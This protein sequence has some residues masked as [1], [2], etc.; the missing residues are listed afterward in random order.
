M[1]SL[2]IDVHPSKT[3]LT[4]SCH[5]NCFLIA[6]PVSAYCL[7]QM[8]L[9]VE[10]DGRTRLSCNALDDRRSSRFEIE[11][12]AT[13]VQTNPNMR[14]RFRMSWWNWEV[15]K[16]LAGSLK[17]FICHFGQN[18]F[19]WISNIIFLGTLT[20]VIPQLPRLSRMAK[21]VSSSVE[22]VNSATSDSVNSCNFAMWAFASKCFPIELVPCS[23]GWWR[24]WWH[25]IYMMPGLPVSLIPQ[26]K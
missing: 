11:F 23:D 16:S 5:G 25:T 8:L 6:S 10:A 2:F 13:C 17:H 19:H 22:L 20:I 21:V 7:W 15:L 4:L 1:H 14:L 18:G 3:K 24:T 26:C 9:R 12:H